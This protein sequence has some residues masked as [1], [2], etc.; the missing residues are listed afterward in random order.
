MGYLAFHR[1]DILFHYVIF[2]IF[3]EKWSNDGFVFVKHSRSKDTPIV[4]LNKIY[5]QGFTKYIYYDNIMYIGNDNGKSSQR[6]Y[7]YP[8]ISYMGDIFIIMK[9]GSLK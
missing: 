4:N 2:L 8:V 7:V 6:G 3:E 5:P 9:A 1:P